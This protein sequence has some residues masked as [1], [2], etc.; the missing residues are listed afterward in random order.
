MSLSIFEN[1][2][3]FGEAANYGPMFRDVVILVSGY[4]QS[5]LDA[6]SSWGIQDRLNAIGWIIDRVNNVSAN[7]FP[8]LTGMT[9]RVYAVVHVNYSQSQIVSSIQRD[10]DG[11]LNVS[12]VSIESDN[13]PA[14]VNNLPQQSQNPQAQTILP[15]IDPNSLPSS[16]PNLGDV[17]GNF[18][19]GLG[20]SAPILLVGGLAVVL[21]LARK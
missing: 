18:A 11:Y 6:V 1:D 17:V 5:A 14:V 7:W 8:G 4:Q 9:F 2:G 21:I 12:G 10:L 15:A 16:A 20:I 19:T 3:T 13:L